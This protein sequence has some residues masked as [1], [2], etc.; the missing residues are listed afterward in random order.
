LIPAVRTRLRGKSIAMAMSRA[1]TLAMLL[2]SHAC[3]AGTLDEI[4]ARGFVSC[5]VT[6][7]DARFSPSAA[8][9][10]RGG[11]LADECRAVAAAVLGRLEVR[12][13]PVAADAAVASLQSGAV[14]LVASA[15]PWSFTRDVSQPLALGG[16]ILF[17]SQGLLVRREEE[18]PDLRDLAGTTVC[19]VR[20]T[21]AE[22]MLQSAHD[23]D[24][25]RL[26]VFE[27]ADAAASACDS[28][29]CAAYAGAR[30]DL[31][32][33]ARALADP[34]THRLL[35]LRAFALPLAVL[36]REGDDRW[37]DIVRWSLNVLVAAEE[38]GV[39]QA[40]VERIRVTSNDP[41]IRRLLGV[42]PGFGTSLGLKDDWACTIIR[43][44]G[45]YADVWKRN[46]STLG[47]ERGVNALWQDGGLSAALP[48]R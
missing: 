24:G 10:A 41:A 26:L 39:D 33:S 25:E 44:V 9:A 2:A 48:F 34:D 28:R 21:L 46:F 36:V 40:G 14:D 16:A 47:L 5:G 30:T 17:E 7:E 6:I 37:A 45:N 20:A 4:R 27:Q 42:D 38:L 12:Y 43:L 8:R 13:V 18:T 22:R 29:R 23:Q 19:V 11:F 35:E 3:A 31:A 1:A 32:A 15:Q